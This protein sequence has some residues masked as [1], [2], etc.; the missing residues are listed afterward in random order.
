[1]ASAVSEG[2]L[3]DTTTLALITVSL[4][5]AVGPLAYHNGFVRDANYA[6]VVVGQ[7]QS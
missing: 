2:F 1:M 5:A 3:R 6:L 4:A 7:G